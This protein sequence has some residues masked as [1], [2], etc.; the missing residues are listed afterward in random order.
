MCIHIILYIAIQHLTS[1][2]GYTTQESKLL[3]IYNIISPR[4][5]ASDNMIS[6][7]L[8]EHL[9]SDNPMHKGK[10]QNLLMKKRMC[11]FS[12]LLTSS[13]FFSKATKLKQND[14]GVG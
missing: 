1:N 10:S 12:T 9:H 3:F 14:R 7:I 4:P 8:L 2:N 11:S 6:Y 13:A 5:S